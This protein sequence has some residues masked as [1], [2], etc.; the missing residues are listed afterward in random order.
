MHNSKI[1]NIVSAF[2]VLF[3]STFCWGSYDFRH[4]SQS[5]LD[6]KITGKVSKE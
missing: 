5:Q 3:V 2:I 1:L 6:L 4:S